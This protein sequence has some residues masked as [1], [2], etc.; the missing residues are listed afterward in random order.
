MSLIIGGWNDA[1]PPPQWTIEIA[2]HIKSISPNSL[3]MDGTMGGLDGPNR[4]QWKALTSNEVDIF[5]NHYYYGEGDYERIKV[6]S[7]HVA[8]YANKVF[9]IGEFGFKYDVCKEIYD[10]TLKNKNVAGALIW[11]LRF[12]S[13]YGTILLNRWVLHTF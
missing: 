7:R 9:V 12:H 4:L 6:D 3:V 2:K 5:S 10:I 1:P 13:R 11:S 8:E